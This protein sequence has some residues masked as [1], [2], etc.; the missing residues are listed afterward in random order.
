MFVSGCV[1]S[2]LLCA[3]SSEADS[4]AGL[5]TDEDAL[6]RV[7]P[8]RTVAQIQAMLPLPIVIPP[9]AAMLPL[10]IAIPPA[11]APDALASAA[12][13]IRA[14]FKKEYG[15]D[16]IAEVRSEVGGILESALAALLYTPAEYDAYQLHKAIGAQQSSPS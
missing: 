4:R 11:A 12:Q 5:G 2:G 10:P 1:P 14:A 6:V 9:A 13:A 7:I 15:K 16:I 8:F 3:V